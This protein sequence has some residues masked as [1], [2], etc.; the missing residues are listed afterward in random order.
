MI[1]SMFF[2]TL[3][4]ILNNGVQ[5]PIYFLIYSTAAKLI[6]L[7]RFQLITATIKLIHVFFTYLF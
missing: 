5:L 1:Y 4:Q 2:S 6:F 3:Q 7:R